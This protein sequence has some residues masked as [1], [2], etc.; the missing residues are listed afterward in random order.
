MEEKR[1]FQAGE[2]YYKDG[3]LY[4]MQACGIPYPVRTIVDG[5][6]DPKTRNRI[7]KLYRWRVNKMPKT[8]KRFMEAL[9]EAM[10]IKGLP[11]DEVRPY[12]CEK[13]GIK[14]KNTFIQLRKKVEFCCFVHTRVRRNASQAK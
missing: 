8:Y 14:G 3:K 12:V 1:E 9:V 2:R 6:E 4:E 5:L 7:W 11:P 10:V 13:L